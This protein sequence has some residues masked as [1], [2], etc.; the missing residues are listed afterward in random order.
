MYSRPLPTTIYCACE[1]HNKTYN[2][3][4][5]LL[6]EHIQH[7]TQTQIAQLRC[8]ATQTCCITHAYI[9]A[10]PHRS[11]QLRW[12]CLSMSSSSPSSSHA[13]WYRVNLWTTTLT[14]LLLDIALSCSVGCFYSLHYR[15]AWQRQCLFECCSPG[16]CA[17]SS[18]SRCCSSQFLCMHPHTD[19]GPL[20]L[21]RQATQSA[22]ACRCN[23]V[24]LSLSPIIDPIHILPSVI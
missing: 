6:W 12:S 22:D 9:R 15:D 5:M 4:I 14:M 20:S 8:A 13:I 18:D 21:W 3:Y 10:P 16:L 17:Q 19:V 7:C 11:I 2:I 1:H 23:T 24:Y